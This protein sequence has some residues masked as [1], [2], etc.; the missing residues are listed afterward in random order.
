MSVFDDIANDKRFL[1]YWG[2]HDDHRSQDRT[3][4]YRP[5]IQQ[6]R[7]EFHEFARV[8]SDKGLNKSCLQLGLGIPGALHNVFQAMFKE[9]WTV[10]NSAATV[11]QFLSR[12]GPQNIIVG[13]THSVE[14][15]N[16]VIEQIGGK[17]IYGSLDLL[18]IDAGHTFDDVSVDFHDYGQLVRSGGIIAMHDALKRPTYDD[19]I[20]VWKFVDMLNTR[21]HGVQMIG[22]ELGIAWIV[23]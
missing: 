4:E 19:E 2:W 13:N 14:T 23:R 3:S 20:Q 16:T 18:F 1:P 10:D 11:D 17:G 9:V 21:G 7:T 22:D 15:Y 8:L 12:V 5:A 6:N